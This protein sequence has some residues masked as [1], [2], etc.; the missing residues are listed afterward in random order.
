MSGV[1]ATGLLRTEVVSKMTHVKYFAPGTRGG[2]EHG[3][4]RRVLVDELRR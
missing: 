3:A 4:R 2:G 1:T